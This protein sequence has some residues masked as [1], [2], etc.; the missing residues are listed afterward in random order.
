[1]T[2]QSLIVVLLRFI[3]LNFVMQVII[4]LALRLTSIMNSYQQL[5]AGE[6]GS[7]I[8]VPALVVLGL[9]AGA[10][11]LWVFAPPLAR[12]VARGLP[13]ELPIGA[14]S[15]K[16]CY[17]ILFVGLGLYY[18]TNNLPGVLNWFHYLLKMRASRPDDDWRQQIN[19]YQVSQPFLSVILGTILFANGR[20][21]AVALVN[22]QIANAT[23]PPPVDPE[24]RPV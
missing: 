16:D 14:L 3:S 11:L 22:R 4:Q 24:Q 19:W 23:Q 12:L 10:V 8:V 6:F 15:L 17:T 21:W 2:L 13:A 1:M 9:L 7:E 20:K 18:A 5:P